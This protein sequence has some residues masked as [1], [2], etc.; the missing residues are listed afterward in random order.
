MRVVTMGMCTELLRRLS[1]R[2]SSCDSRVQ[3][4]SEGIGI[5]ECVPSAMMH[6]RVPAF[7]KAYI[8]SLY[9]VHDTWD[10]AIVHVNVWIITA[11][12]YYT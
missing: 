1:Q 7:A 9:V 11:V 10:M 4:A 3:L 5:N 8:M 6:E 12:L 2:S